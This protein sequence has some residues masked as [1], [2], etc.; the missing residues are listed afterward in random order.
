MTDRKPAIFYGGYETAA[1]LA[2]GKDIDALHKELSDLIEDLS[3]EELNAL[4]WATTNRATFKR[5]PSN[6]AGNLKAHVKVTIGAEATLTVLRKGSDGQQVP[7]KAPEYLLYLFLTR[8]NRKAMFGDLEE[9]FRT[10]ILTRF[11]ARRAR[12]WFWWQV[13]R[14][15]WPSVSGSISKLAWWLITRLTS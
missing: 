1:K 2:T 7:P 11:G 10:E 9:E 4:K 3:E 15:V 14:S 6:T 5:R 12:L 8:D 13:V